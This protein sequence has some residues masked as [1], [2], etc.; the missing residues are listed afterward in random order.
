VGCG[1][2]LLRQQCDYGIAEVILSPWPRLR[3]HKHL[4]PRVLADVPAAL[5]FPFDR[6][7]KQSFRTMMNER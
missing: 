1:G 4:H 7:V 3:V 6:Q 2:A 5:E